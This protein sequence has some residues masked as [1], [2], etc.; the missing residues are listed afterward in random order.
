MGKCLQQIKNLVHFDNTR[1][2]MQKCYLF[3]SFCYYLHGISKK[4][5]L[6]YLA[7]INT[8]IV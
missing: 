5:I 4:N 1:W 7:L 3:V 8:N 2:T 6:Q